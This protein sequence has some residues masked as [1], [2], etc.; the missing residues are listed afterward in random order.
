MH[1]DTRTLSR[2]KANAENLAVG[3]EAAV[4][5]HR[6]AQHRLGVANRGDHEKKFGRCDKCDYVVIAISQRNALAIM[7]RRKSKLPVFCIDC[8]HASGNRRYQA[9]KAILAKRGIELVGLKR[10]RRK[11]AQHGEIEARS[12]IAIMPELVKAN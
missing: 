11:N 12:S 8:M 3:R 4:S 10:V 2:I 9:K 5:C 1:H 7:R 6:R